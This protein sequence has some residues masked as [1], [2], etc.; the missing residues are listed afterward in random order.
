MKNGQIEKYNRR[1]KT[2]T[3]RDPGPT[4][5]EQKKIKLTSVVKQITS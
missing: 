2:K 1:H 5:S 4:G 3:D